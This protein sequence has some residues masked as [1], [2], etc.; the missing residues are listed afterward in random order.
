MSD[1]DTTTPVPAPKKSKKLLIAIVAAVALLG[2]GGGGAYYLTSKNSSQVATKGIITPLK[3]SLTMNLADGHYLKLNFAI[4]QT[5]A[6]G[7]TAVDPAQAVN[8]A[9][10]VYTGKTLAALSTA[11]ER[12]T[13]KTELLTALENDYNTKGN[14]V[15]MDVYYTAF[16]TQ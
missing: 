11:K 5:S 9:L 8:S 6:S 15:V 13:A 7:T 4:Q 2:G 1:N 12:D 3:D 16:V 14:Q 10:G